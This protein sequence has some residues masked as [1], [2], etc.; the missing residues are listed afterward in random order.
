MLVQHVQPGDP[1]QF[2]ERLQQNQLVSMWTYHAARNLLPRRSIMCLLLCG[3]Q[4]H[5]YK[6]ERE[7][8][9][10]HLQHLHHLHHLDYDYDDYDLP[11]QPPQSPQQARAPQEPPPESQ[12]P[13]ST[14]TTVPLQL[15]RCWMEDVR[16]QDSLKMGKDP[17]R[18]GAGLDI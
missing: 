2:C 11:S 12:E 13:S 8:F 1:S 5:H 4:H 14:C 15:R 17:L 7:W 9:P 16:C 18:A 10:S 6:C 3:Y